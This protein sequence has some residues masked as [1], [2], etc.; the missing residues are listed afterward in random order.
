M[1]TAHQP[2]VTTAHQPSVTTAH[3]P[4]VTTAHHPSVTTTHQPSVTTAHQSAVTTAHQPSVTTAALIVTTAHQPSVT[5]AHQPS[6][7]TARQCILEISVHF[8]SVPTAI[9]ARFPSVRSATNPSSAHQSTPPICA[10]YQP[11]IVA[12]QRRCTLKWR[13]Q[14][15][16]PPSVPIMRAR[17]RP[18]APAGPGQG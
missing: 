14:S 12:L 8:P 10:F 6:V 3:Q 16:Q 15:A 17:T 13:S 9:L 7:S 4:S 1:T 5:T 18:G 11:L 2:S